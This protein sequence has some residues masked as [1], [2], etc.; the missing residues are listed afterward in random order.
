MIH[1]H[2]HPIH[3]EDVEMIRMYLL[4][5]GTVCHTGDTSIQSDIEYLYHYFSKQE[6]NN[7]WHP[8]DDDALYMFTNWL[9][10]LEV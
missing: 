7:D 8:V 9:E 3:F 2:R 6:F 4:K 1:W 10:D 5:H